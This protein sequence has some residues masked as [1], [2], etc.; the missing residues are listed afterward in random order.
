MP[1]RASLTLR[2][3]VRYFLSGFCMGC[4]D[5]VPGVSGGTVA[6]IM[7]FY[8]RLIDA[9]KGFNVAALV[10]IVRL[11]FKAFRSQYDWDFLTAL[12][13]GAAVALLTL[14]HLFDFLLNDPFWRTLLFAAFF[15]LI[16]A[17]AHFCSKKIR[18]IGCHHVAISIAAGALAFLITLLPTQGGAEGRYHV[19]LPYSTQY[20]GAYNY[21]SRRQLLLNVPAATVAAMVAKETI[22]RDTIVYDSVERKAEMAG[23]FEVALPPVSSVAPWVI[24]CGALTI[25][26]MLLPGI[27]GSY[28]MVV[29]GMYPALIGAVADFS[30]ALRYGTWDGEAALFLTNFVVGLIAGALL[31]SRLI[32]W[33]LERYY[34]ITI[35]ALI[36]FMVGALR[37]IWPFWS[38]QVHLLPLKLHKGLRL[39]VVEPLLPPLDSPLFMVVI[40]L[41]TAAF[42]AVM[43]LEKVVNR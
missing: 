16:L 26:A 6:F 20:D 31:F 28:L 3:W 9:I 41:A 23:E 43:M 40:F 42:A 18:P 13:S 24:A 27:S 34:S 32:G 15:G 14:A 4:A 37:V 10:L 21:D 30:S 11:R 7:G 1:E 22:P 12:T 39:E 38:Y 36:G 5:L 8:E 25:S 33:A 2:Q 19:F 29:A 17:S 35:A